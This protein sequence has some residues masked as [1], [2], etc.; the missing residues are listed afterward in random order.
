MVEEED[1]DLL[2]ISDS[3]YYFLIYY[4][5]VILGLNLGVEIYYDV[6]WCEEEVL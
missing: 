4:S 1:L 6:F 3:L 5:H 2:N